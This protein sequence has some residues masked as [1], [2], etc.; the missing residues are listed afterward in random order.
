MC[1][2]T[3]LRS[4][5]LDT[6][7]LAVLGFTSTPFATAFTTPSDTFMRMLCHIRPFRAPNISIRK[8]IIGESVRF[9]INAIPV[10][11]GDVRPPPTPTLRAA[12]T[13]PA[14]IAHRLRYLSASRRVPPH[15]ASI[16][17]FN[18]CI[19]GQAWD[20]RRFAM[21]SAAHP[22]NNFERSNQGSPCALAA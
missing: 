18:I 21:A 5:Q 12:S 9:Y 16:V 22:T 17:D 14:A 20:R 11:A 15:Q 1:I 10:R 19:I 7:P 8:M 2:L 3:R 6:S 4:T 13:S